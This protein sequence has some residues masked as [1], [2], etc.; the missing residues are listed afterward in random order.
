MGRSNNNAVSLADI[1]IAVVGENG[2]RDD[3]GGGIAIVAV[4]HN[5]Y[6]VGGKN[7]KRA[8]HRRS[9]ESVGIA[10]DKE[11]S[12][13]S[14]LRAVFTD[15]LGDSHDM[16]FG[17]ATVERSPAMT[18]GSEGNPLGGIIQIGFGLVVERDEF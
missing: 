12:G 10:T 4:D 13:G 15:R 17:K 16:I 11:G 14:L 7:L 18:G 9:R 3:G 5:G 1:P 8:F 2:M 6:A